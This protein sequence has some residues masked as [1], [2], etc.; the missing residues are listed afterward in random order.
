MKQSNSSNG[1]PHS[2]TAS[3]QV[4]DELLDVTGVSQ[5]SSPAEGIHTIF[6]GIYLNLGF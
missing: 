4:T 5:I 6:Q 2:T 3:N 1:G